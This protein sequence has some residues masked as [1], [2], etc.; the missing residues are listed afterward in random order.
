LVKKE[1]VYSGDV[2]N[3]TARIV[4]LCNQYKAPLII[5]APL[6]EKLKG[7]TGYQFKYLDS[8][9]LRGKAAKLGLYSVTAQ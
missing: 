9:D 6:Y 3:T 8:P 2:L 7:T 4:A 5:S 1:I